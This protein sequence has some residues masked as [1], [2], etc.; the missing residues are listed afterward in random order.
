MVYH[1]TEALWDTGWPYYHATDGEQTIMSITLPAGSYAVTARLVA[2]N[3]GP[4]SPVVECRL[5]G[6]SS[7]PY[8]DF[9]DSTLVSGES[10][11]G[12][13]NLVLQQAGTLTAETQLTVS[14]SISNANGPVT[15]SSGEITA[16]QESTIVELPPQ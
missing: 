1:T 8:P 5:N 16:Q 14:C 4:G 7:D 11:E 10:A 2:S 13:Y 3:G 15:Y 9:T 12:F 6:L